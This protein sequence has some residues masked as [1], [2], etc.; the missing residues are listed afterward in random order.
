[1]IIRAP[2]GSE[3]RILIRDTWNTAIL[4]ELAPGAGDVVLYKHRYSGFFGGARWLKD[5]LF[6]MP[7]EVNA[8]YSQGR[9]GYLSAMD[10]VIGQVADI[11]GGELNRARVRIAQGRADVR[12]Y[13]S[14]L[15]ADLQQVGKDAEG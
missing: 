11:V 13:V 3:S 12:T 10:T 14:K 9:V 8:F 1:M 5:K 6:G 4:P 15:P 7:D 2:D